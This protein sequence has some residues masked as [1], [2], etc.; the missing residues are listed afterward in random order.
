[1]DF[2]TMKDLDLLILA[3]IGLDRKWEQREAN[4]ITEEEEEMFD[5][6]DSELTLKIMALKSK[7][8]KEGDIDSYHFWKPTRR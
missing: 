8:R 2:E 4:G 1:M 6:M 7:A 3:R 5:K